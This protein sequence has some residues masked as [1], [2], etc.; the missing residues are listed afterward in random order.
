MRMLKNIAVSLTTGVVAVL[1]L[2]APAVAAPAGLA[3]GLLT[4]KDLPAGKGW[5]AFDA[6]V[7][8]VGLLPGLIDPN[9]LGGDPCKMPD[10]P[11]LKNLLA[12]ATTQPVA[13]RAAGKVKL[14]LA[15]FMKGADGPMLLQTLAGT[16]KK[17]AHDLVD[18]TR[19]MLKRCPTTKSGNITMEMSALPKFPKVGD[20]SQAISVVVT[21]KDGNF[22]IAVPGKLVAVAQDDVYATVA[23]VGSE[24][25]DTAELK[26]L[27]KRALKKL[28]KAL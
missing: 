18:G 3:D 6:E 28:D 12:P 26:K 27:T 24:E 16:G 23:L 2:S 5:A 17:A 7:M 4:E 14:E 10:A 8:G 9:S 20:D 22:E 13:P 25:P 11:P 15:A 21:L 19:D 1:A